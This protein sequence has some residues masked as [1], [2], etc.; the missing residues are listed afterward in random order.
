MKNVICFLFVFWQGTSFA[1]VPLEGIIFGGVQ[2]IQQY[3]PFTGVL[4]FDYTKE[5]KSD[6]FESQKIQHYYAL[7]KQGT[8]LKNQCEK[9]PKTNYADK[10]QMAIA[11]RSIAAT[12]QYIGLDLSL[13]A[14]AKYAK[15]LEYTKDQYSTLTKNLIHTTCTKNLSVYSLKLLSDNF[16]KEWEDKINILPTIKSSPYFEKDIK[17]R[18]NTMDVTKREFNYTIRNFRAFCSWNSDSSDY[19]MLVPYLKNPYIMSVVFN[20]LNKKKLNVDQKTKE[21]NLIKNPMSAQVACE[22]LICRNRSSIDFKLLYPRMIGSTKLDDDFTS[23]YCDH[24]LTSRYQK[25]KTNAKI[26]KWLN[27]QS[28]EE[29]KLETLNFISLLTNVP[30]PLI[31]AN[32]Y[33][34]IPKFILNNIKGRWDKWAEKKIGQF[35]NDHL[36]EE[37]LEVK[38]VTQKGTEKVQNGEFNILFDVGLSEIDKVLDGVDKIDSFFNLDIP[39]KYLAYIKEKSSYHYNRSEFGKVKHIEDNFINT[40]KHQLKSKSAYFKIPIWNDEI[41]GIIAEEIMLQASQYRGNGLSKLST[42]QLKIPIRFRFGLFALHY[43][44][45]KNKFL[46]NERKTLT[47]N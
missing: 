25:T 46:E 34:Q 16:K 18:H 13:K 33:N 7:Y 44:R 28:L 42:K 15:K 9:D 2:D 21:L 35:H 3:D 27:E 10:W 11:T 36:Y 38:L 8:N 20:N 47:F 19:R 43:V 29:S 37:P 12:L 24:F 14:I 39:V 1:L 31:I 30:D 41:A 4:S 6:N 22:D 26:K 23:L 5:N 45:Q 40:I 17:Q 32:N